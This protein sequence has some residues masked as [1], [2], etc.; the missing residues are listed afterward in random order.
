MTDPTKAHHV[1]STRHLGQT[2]ALYLEVC[3]L[4]RLLREGVALVAHLEGMVVGDH[5]GNR[6]QAKGWRERCGEVLG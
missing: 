6:A 2:E 1:D 3:E 4:R 5:P